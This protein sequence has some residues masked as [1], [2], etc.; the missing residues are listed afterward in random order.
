MMALQSPTCANKNEKLRIT[1]P[2]ILSPESLMPSCGNEN[3]K[4]EM[5]NPVTVGQ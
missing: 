5:I 2:V 1:K 3:K 4:I